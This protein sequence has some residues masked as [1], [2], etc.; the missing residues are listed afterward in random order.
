MSRNSVVL[1][2]NDEG[3]K[4]VRSLCAKAGLPMEVLE[5]LITEEIEQLGK[6]RKAGLWDEFDRIFDSMETDDS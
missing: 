4:L 1:L 5:E 2:S 6:K 3:R